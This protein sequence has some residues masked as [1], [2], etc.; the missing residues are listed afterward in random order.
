MRSTFL[1]S[2]ANARTQKA[3]SCTLSL[4][5]QI[6]QQLAVFGNSFLLGKL[7]IVNEELS[8]TTPDP[9]C[10]QASQISCPLF[11]FLCCYI[12]GSAEPAC[13]V[14]PCLN[15][16]EVFQVC[17]FGCYRSVGRQSPNFN[18]KLPSIVRL[19]LHQS[20]IHAVRPNM[21]SCHP[22]CPKS[23]FVSHLT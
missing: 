3:I 4:S 15:V 18:R 8:A 23:V 12:A 22:A 17:L 10:A 1:K 7:S 20:H 9:I 21:Q 5:A 13:S 19:S 6:P 2:T 16:I 14:L 11:S